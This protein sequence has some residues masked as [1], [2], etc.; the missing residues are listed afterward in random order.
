MSLKRE[1]CPFP[2][3]Q[4]AAGFHPQWCPASGPDGLGGG[5]HH[6]HSVRQKMNSYYEGRPPGWYGQ[7]AF[8]GEPSRALSSFNLWWPCVM[9]G[10]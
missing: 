5:S 9:T 1:L 8:R 3:C 2:A 6:R 4:Q 10:S 7:K